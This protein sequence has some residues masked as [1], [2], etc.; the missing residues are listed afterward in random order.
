MGR[1]EDLEFP[2]SFVVFIE[3][4]PRN[5]APVSLFPQLTWLEHTE[6]GMVP[7]NL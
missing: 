7:E 1:V 5:S 6:V 2:A 4:W 3:C